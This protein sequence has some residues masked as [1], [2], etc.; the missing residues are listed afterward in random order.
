MTIIGIVGT[1]IL[2]PIFSHT[3]DPAPFWD[4][5]ITVA[6]LIAEYM[7]CIKLYEAW[8]L[9]FAADVVSL[10]VL[11]AL[12]M[13]IT[14]GTYGVFTILCVMGIIAWRKSL[15]PLTLAWSSESSIR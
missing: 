11:A 12:G 4:S 13:W 1:V 7:L 3:G 10:I 6:S 9:Y 5:V 15:K 8:G 14:F 2:Y